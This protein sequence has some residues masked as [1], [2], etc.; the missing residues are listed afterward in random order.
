M[1]L[2]RKFRRMKK[3]DKLPVGVTITMVAQHMKISIATVKR[4]LIDHHY[5]NGEFI[6]DPDTVKQHLQELQEK[7]GTSIDNILVDN[8]DMGYPSIC[9]NGQHIK[10][11]IMNDKW[12]ELSKTEKSPGLFNL[13]PG[14]KAPNIDINKL[15]NS[16]KTRPC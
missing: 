10:Y 9:D 1:S 12:K 2:E 4:R 11:W 15:Q 14:Q 6:K 3:N 5:Y 13:E 16:N 7:H 8:T